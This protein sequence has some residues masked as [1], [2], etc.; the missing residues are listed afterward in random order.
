M[1]NFAVAARLV[2]LQER[3]R[4]GTIEAEKTNPGHKSGEAWTQL[5][6]VLPGMF[7]DDRGPYWEVSV[8]SYVLGPNRQHRWQGGTAAEALALAERDVETW[9]VPFEVAAFEKTMLGDDGDDWTRPPPRAPKDDP[10]DQSVGPDDFADHF[11][12]AGKSRKRRKKPKDD[13]EIAF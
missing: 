5:S 4:W 9:V 1:I 6:F 2:R 8:Y 10:Q 12:D 7:A 13:D 11:P 3:V